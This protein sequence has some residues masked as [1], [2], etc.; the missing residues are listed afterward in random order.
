[1]RIL[2]LAPRAESL[3]SSR[4]RHL[5]PTVRIAHPLPR[6]YP[7]QPSRGPCLSSLGLWAATS[8][9]YRSHPQPYPTPDPSHSHPTTHARPDPTLASPFLLSLLAPPYPPCS[10][11]TDHCP[12]GHPL[13]RRRRPH[14]TS[15]RI[16]M[17]FTLSPCRRRSRS[18]SRNH[19]PPLL[20]HFV[21]SFCLSL[22][23][24]RLNRSFSSLQATP[25]ARSSR[26]HY[27]HH[28][29][30]LPYPCHLFPNLK[31]APHQ[32]HLHLLGHRSPNESSI[33]KPS[34]SSK[35]IWPSTLDIS[36][37]R[38]IGCRKLLSPS[39]SPQ[40]SVIALSM[41]L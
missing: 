21:E 32:G 29:C 27:H 19:S 38:I 18:S 12:T 6:A 16:F 25:H 36:A 35:Q 40:Q 34:G 1:M 11:S 14:L 41:A 24:G 5:D 33:G 17:I 13:D 20:C 26:R 39:S 30:H 31:V 9:L 28:L 3:D 8:H 22:V 4:H 15:D 2:R 37:V 23:S 10:D 7:L